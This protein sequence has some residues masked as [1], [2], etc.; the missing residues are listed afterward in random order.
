MTTICN[1]RCDCFLVD[2]RI[3]R[4]VGM[5]KR[6]DGLEVAAFSEPNPYVSCVHRRELP[7]PMGGRV[8]SRS[9]TVMMR[10]PARARQSR[11]GRT[12]PAPQAEP[13]RQMGGERSAQAI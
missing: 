9:I 12:C 13:A 10:S 1:P 6:H 4:K 8:G 7:A 3:V 11:T 2:R 5:D